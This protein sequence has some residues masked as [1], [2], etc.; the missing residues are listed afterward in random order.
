MLVLFFV[1]TLAVWFL[2]IDRRFNKLFTK[3][4]KLLEL[5][6][7]AYNPTPVGKSEV[8]DNTL[9]KHNP[10]S[11]QQSYHLFHY[12]FRI[13]QEEVILASYYSTNPKMIMVYGSHYYNIFIKKPDIKEFSVVPNVFL[14]TSRKTF[15]ETYTV[16]NENNI[17]SFP[18]L[19]TILW[20]SYSFKK[21]EIGLYATPGMLIISSVAKQIEDHFIDV[22]LASAVRLLKVIGKDL[23]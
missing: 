13:N 17:R 10:Y 2:L 4:R 9:P 11:R 12:K 14:N 3:H 15:K 6:L 20:G 7:Q 23:D 22:F 5:G 19:K 16:V 1:L 21:S 8:L 18:K